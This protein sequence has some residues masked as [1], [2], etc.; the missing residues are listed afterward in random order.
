[1]WWVSSE[2]KAC[3]GSFLQAFWVLAHS[4]SNSQMHL[5]SRIHRAELRPI[6][7]VDQRL[8]LNMHDHIWPAVAVYVS[9]FSSYR[10]QVLPIAKQCR[11]IVDTRLRG[12]ST[13]HLDNQHVAIQI[14]KDKMRGISH[15]VIMADHCINLKSSGATVSHILL[16]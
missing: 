2:V 8:I 14:E 13:W 10:R 3:R 1:M 9:K 6:I 5:F 12:V 11:A 16:V 7:N 15:A 4:L